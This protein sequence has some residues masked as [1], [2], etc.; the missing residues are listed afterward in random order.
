MYLYPDNLSGKATLFVWQLRDIVMI[1]S[2]VLFGVL[3]LA[4]TGSMFL[5]VLAG[6]SCFL[7]IRAG[8]ASILDFIRYA[9]AYFFLKQQ[10]YEWRQN[11]KEREID[12]RIDGNS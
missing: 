7:T 5:L 10:L 11:E 8:D 3:M 2:L 12:Q 9:A 4:N 1:V 6:T